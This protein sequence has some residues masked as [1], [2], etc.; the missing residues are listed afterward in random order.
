MCPGGVTVSR[1]LLP[2]YFQAKFSSRTPLLPV[3][4][5]SC[6]R[7][8]CWADQLPLASGISESKGNCGTCAGDVWDMA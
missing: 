1:R 7:A 5:S 8:V 3:S 4:Q 6:W 2:T